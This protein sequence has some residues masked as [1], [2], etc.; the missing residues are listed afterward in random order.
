MSLNALCSY[1]FLETMAKITTY[2]VT[3]PQNHPEIHNNCKLLY[4]LV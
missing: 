2:S 4:N 1:F 3:L